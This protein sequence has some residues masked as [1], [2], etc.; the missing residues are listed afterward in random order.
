MLCSSSTTRIFSA[1]IDV[2]FLLDDSGAAHAAR[3]ACAATA[4]SVTRTVVP[5]LET[6]SN[7]S[8]PP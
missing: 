6:L 8:E 4:G 1:G 5:W 7:E 3:A 2:T